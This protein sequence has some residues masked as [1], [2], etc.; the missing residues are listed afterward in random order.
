[1]HPNFALRQLTDRVRPDDRELT[2]VRE[3]VASVLTNLATVV[4]RSRIVG[5]GSYSRRTA[6]AFHTNVDIL[7]VLPREWGTRPVSPLS[8]V[9]RMAENLSDARCTPCIRRDCRAVELHFKGT[10][11][12]PEWHNMLFAAADARCG[13]KLCTISQLL[14]V[15]RYAGSSQHGISG[16]YMDMILATSDI[17]SGVK[18]YGQCVNDFFK[19]LI[20]RELRG[21]LDFASKSHGRISPIS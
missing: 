13:K 16:F 9:Q 4:P 18:S 12:A 15:W 19:E 2:M 21:P 14:K 5:V 10:K 6:I 8:I 20:G 7:A 17:G 1:M 3:Q 11:R